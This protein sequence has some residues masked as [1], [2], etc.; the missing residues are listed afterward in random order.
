[1]KGLTFG[2]WGLADQSLQWIGRSAAWFL[3]R[4]HFPND[5]GALS[6]ATGGS[7]VCTVLGGAAGFALAEISRNVGTIDGTMLGAALG[8]CVG[9]IFG[10]SVDTVSSTINDLVRSL[11]LK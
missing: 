6:A 7:L 4:R 1:M 5:E 8:V 3:F 10:A 2:V 11:G 9:F